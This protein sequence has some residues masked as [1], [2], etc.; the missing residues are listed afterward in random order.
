MLGLMRW[1]IIRFTS[2]GFVVRMILLGLVALIVSG[3]GHV[4]GN[5]ARN[6]SQDV[7]ELV[8]S[9]IDRSAEYVVDTEAMSPKLGYTP[10]VESGSWIN[11][12]GTCSTPLPIGPED[13]VS[14][15]RSH[16][17]GYDALRLAAG[18]GSVLG[19]WA[20]FGLDARLYS[21]LLQ[22][23]DD[24]G[25][26][27]TAAVYF[28][29]VTLNSIRQGYGSPTEEPVIPWAGLGL[30]IVALAAFN[31]ERYRGD[32][33][34]DFVSTR[35]RPWAGPTAPNPGTASPVHPPSSPS[36]R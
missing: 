8:E 9:L 1:V 10:I 29:A 7:T 18:D 13:F 14:P 15:C 23:C 16:D 21:D 4:I 2:V 27:A 31:P 17:L 19:A 22:A 30:A 11:P 36:A 3:I 28:G 12:T 35:F 34:R 33:C 20:R 32:T 6:E 24:A 5:P 25:C 26:Q